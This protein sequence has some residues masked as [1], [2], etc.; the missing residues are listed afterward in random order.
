MTELCCDGTSEKR[1]EGAGYFP[2]IDGLRGLAILG[3]LANHFMTFP[4]AANGGWLGV[5][6]FFV[7]SGFLITGILLR[8][9]QQ[10]ERGGGYRG[11][12]RVFYVRRALRIF[13]AYFLTVLVLW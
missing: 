11:A 13:P 5:C 8:A 1:G 2:Q 4:G 12:L 3:V 9:R 7:L 10:A 6:L